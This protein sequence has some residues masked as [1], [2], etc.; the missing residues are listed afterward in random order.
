MIKI[1]L[2]EKRGEK[3]SGVKKEFV[4]AI[5]A[6]VVLVGLLGL[7]HWKMARDIDTT[8]KEVAQ[9]KEQIKFYEAQIVKASKV[10]TFTVKPIARMNA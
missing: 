4:V 6:F 2:L 8:Q 5:A 3:K 10:I 9:T 7:V 1:N